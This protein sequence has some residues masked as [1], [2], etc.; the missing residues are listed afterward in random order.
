VA[1][2]YEV[3][4]SVQLCLEDRGLCS[5]WKETGRSLETSGKVD[6]HRMDDVAVVLSTGPEEDSAYCHFPTGSTAV[7]RRLSLR[8]VQAKK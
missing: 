8:T 3:L 2:W 6:Q 4:Y 7:L 5:S 1:E